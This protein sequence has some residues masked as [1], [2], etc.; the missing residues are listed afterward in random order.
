MRTGHR[1]IPQHQPTM[2]LGFMEGCN[3]AHEFG[4]PVGLAHER[5]DP[6]GGMRYN[7]ATVIRDFSGPHNRRP[8]LA[9]RRRGT[10]T[11]PACW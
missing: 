9:A 3:T 5:Q 4:N 8:A 10:T 11:G 1:G 7:E 2:R 6:D